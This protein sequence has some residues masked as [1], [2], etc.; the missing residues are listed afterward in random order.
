MRLIGTLSDQHDAATLV[1]YLLTR[2]IGAK[3]ERGGDAWELW[4]LDEDRVGDAK[5]VLADFQ[6]NKSDPKYAA[7]AKEADRLRHER[8]EKALEAKKNLIRLP[9]SAARTRGR[10]PLTMLLLTA[11]AVVFVLSDFGTKREGTDRLRITEYRV[12]ENREIEQN[13]ISYRADL[14]ELR[15]G[16]FWRAFSPMLIHSTIIHFVFNMIWLVEFGSQIEARR[17]TLI[18]ALLVALAS[19]AGNLAQFWWSGPSFGGMSGVNYGLFGYLFIKSRYEPWL[20]FRLHQNTV[21]LMIGWFFLCMTGWVGPIANYAHL[22]GLIGGV[23]FAYAPI[24]LRTL[25]GKR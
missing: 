16:Q 10:R 21:F 20:G 5:Q 18:F 7:A 14:P 3:A 2:E 1:D 12:T 4:I 19:A 13:W 11:S 15:E 25:R 6:L 24:A 9:S 23:V 22:F 8:V 17:G